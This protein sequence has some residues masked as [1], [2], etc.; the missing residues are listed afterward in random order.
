MKKVKELWGWVEKSV[1]YKKKCVADNA[2]NSEEI[3][4]FHNIFTAGD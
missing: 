4:R 1:A 3:V 2:G